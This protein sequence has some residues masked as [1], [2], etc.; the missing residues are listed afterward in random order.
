M[1]PLILIVDDDDG[2]L[3][4]LEA[5]L[6]LYGFRTTTAMTC[7]EA[8]ECLREVVPDLIVLDLMLPDCD[9]VEFC[10][11]LRQE[12]FKVPVIML[13]AKDRV[14]DR[15][16]GLESGADDYVVKP[17]ETVELVA[18]IKAC[19]RRYENQWKE[20]LRVGPFEIDPETRTVKLEGKKVELT[21]KEF[22][23][24]YLLARNPGRVL[25]REEIRKALWKDQRKIYSWS[26]VID[27]HIQH[28]R[29]KIEKDPANPCYIR[30]VPGVG[31]KFSLP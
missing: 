31:Y 29:K 19:L 22:D 9:G 10:R 3:K 16:L 11:T 1:G 2:I 26:R 8:K 5:N 13:T 27:V 30:T 21:T 15:V 14:S 25:S 12:G 28:L 6:G 24:L 17:F 23:L 4:V 7:H 20:V 18:R